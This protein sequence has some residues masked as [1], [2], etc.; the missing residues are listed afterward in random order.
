MNAAGTTPAAFCVALRPALNPRAA[1]LRGRRDL[2]GGHHK[3]KGN[4]DVGLPGA[5]GAGTGVARDEVAQGVGEAFLDPVPHHHAGSGS[6]G[7]KETG[8]RGG[9]QT[10][11]FIL[12]ARLGSRERAGR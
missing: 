1:P 12:W 10:H 11:Q 5:D 9:G 4:D 8:G 2:L 7:G 6:S 3:V